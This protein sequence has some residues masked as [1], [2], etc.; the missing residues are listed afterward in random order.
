MPVKT[1]PLAEADRA[2]RMLDA[3]LPDSEPGETMITVWVPDG[4][5]ERIR[6]LAEVFEPVWCTAWRDAAHHALWGP[7]GL[8]QHPQ[9]PSVE[10]QDLKL[11][12]ILRFAGD[13]PWALI[14]DDVAFELREFPG[15]LPDE[16]PHLLVGPDPAVGITDEHVRQL[17]DFAGMW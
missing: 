15:R 5:G 2:R 14:D 3:L 4:A 1:P 17:I 8:P 6:R 10:W 16:P 11:P 12:A 13:R 9:W 7:L